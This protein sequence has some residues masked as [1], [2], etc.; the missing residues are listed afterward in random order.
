MRVRV[1]SHRKL[2]ASCSLVGISEPAHKRA[3]TGLTK[4][5]TYTVIALKDS[6]RQLTIQAMY[7]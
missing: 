4:E 6:F 1:F 2:C 5:E 7:V 3:V